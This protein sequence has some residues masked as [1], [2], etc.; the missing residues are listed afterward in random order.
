MALLQ[1]LKNLF[2]SSKSADAGLETAGKH[3]GERAREQVVL[4]KPNSWAEFP[5][6]QFRIHLPSHLWSGHV[7]WLEYVARKYYASPVPIALSL[8][9]G[10]GGFERHGL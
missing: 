9:C 2:K 6:R 5:G 3:W 10:G 7:G 8:G 4:N 1:S